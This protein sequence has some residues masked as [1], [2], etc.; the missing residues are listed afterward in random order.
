MTCHLTHLETPPVRRVVPDGV[1]DA[2]GWC[3][4]DRLAWMHPRPG[5]LPTPIGMDN[6]AG[7]VFVMHAECTFLPRE[8]ARLHAPWV[9]PEDAWALAPWGIDAATDGLWEAR[10]RPASLLSLAAERLDQVVWGLHD[11]A[12]FHAHGPFEQ[13]AWTELQC[14]ATAL[15]WLWLNRGALGVSDA[16]WEDA[17]RDLEALSATRFAEEAEPFDPAPLGAAAVKA[18][19]S[20]G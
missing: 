4:S 17:R 20:G 2:F 7:F 15:A 13:R 8:L 16:T 10:V 5:L 18:L 19:L 12:H 1:F 14:D 3:A 11:W 9:E 6:P